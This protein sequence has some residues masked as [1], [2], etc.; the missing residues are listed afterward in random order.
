MTRRARSIAGCCSCRTLRRPHR[1]RPRPPFW[2]AWT[3]CCAR[4]GRRSPAE[5]LD[6]ERLRMTPFTLT[7]RGEENEDEDEEGIPRGA[8]SSHKHACGAPLRAG[9]FSLA[10]SLTRRSPFPCAPRGGVRLR[11]AR[12]A[13]GFS[14]C[15]RATPGRGQLLGSQPFSSP[16]QASKLFASPA[17]GGAHRAW[18]SFL[19]EREELPNVSGLTSR[20]RTGNTLCRSERASERGRV[21]VYRQSMVHLYAASGRGRT[22][23]LT[24]ATSAAQDVAGQPGGWYLIRPANSIRSAA[25]PASHLCERAS[26]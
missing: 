3:R 8:H 25:F 22:R 15:L 18:T 5:G 10:L 1:S 14:P 13:Q 20:A 4:T 24:N 16:S 17:A 23:R 6:P 19:N 26:L 11:S 9:L 2:R 7:R 12:G 21:Y